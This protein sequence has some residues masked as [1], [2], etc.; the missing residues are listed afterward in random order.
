[1]LMFSTVIGCY[2]DRSD[3]NRDL[4]NIPTRL[5]TNNTQDYCI[6]HC[7]TS[8]SIGYIK[9]QFA[10]IIGI[11]RWCCQNYKF[12]FV[13]K[14]RCVFGRNILKHLFHQFCCQMDVI[15]YKKNGPFYSEQRRW[16]I[17]ILHELQVH[18]FN[19]TY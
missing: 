17:P 1:M 10:H 7:L 18:I 5:Y 13:L 11:Q 2:A 19:V 16:Y 15:L 9:I 12:M 4:P 14:H 3:P 8:V 6:D